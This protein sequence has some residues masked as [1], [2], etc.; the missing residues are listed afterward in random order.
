M[1][2][3]RRRPKPTSNV[4]FCLSPGAPS[5]K[6]RVKMEESRQFN[7]RR[8]EQEIN[9]PMWN[10]TRQLLDAFYEP[11]NRQLAELLNDSRYLW[12]T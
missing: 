10:E 3:Q 2:G 5:A 8:P 12:K 9:G 11:Y 1:L 6:N 4:M 7:L